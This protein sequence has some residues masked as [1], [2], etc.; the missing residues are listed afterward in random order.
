[1]QRTAKLSQRRAGIVPALLLLASSII[2]TPT[3]ATTD[4][5]PD[6]VVAMPVA[7]LAALLEA[8]WIEAGDQIALWEL[9][10]TH[11]LAFAQKTEVAMVRKHSPESGWR[12]YIIDPFADAVAATDARQQQLAYAHVEPAK[13]FYRAALANMPNV[14][15]LRFQYAR[16]LEESGARDDAITQ[17]RR[18]IEVTDEALLQHAEAASWYAA[19][20]ARHLI[21]LLD[22]NQDGEEIRRL[23]LLR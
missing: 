13:V 5:T 21:P 7:Q 15:G 16:L 18:I 6:E 20:A 19:T 3:H 9:A 17:Y 11:A 23:R 8:R 10:R 1:M 14:M 22:G 4:V 12:Y 2:T